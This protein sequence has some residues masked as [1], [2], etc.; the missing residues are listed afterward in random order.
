M[1]LKLNTVSACQGISEQ[2]EL[3][4]SE[5]EDH[6]H[7]RDSKK[8][9]KSRPRGSARGT[10]TVKLTRF[11]GES[12]SGGDEEDSDI[13]PVGRFADNAVI[14]IEKNGYC[15]EPQERSAKLHAPEFFITLK[16]KAL[17]DSIDEHRP[18]EQLHMLPRGLVHARKRR[19]PSRLAR[20]IVQK[21]K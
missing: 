21:M 13:D 4:C 8:Q 2:F 12:D 6:E 9:C 3:G 16:E 14:G 17:R 10:A 19:Y 7:S 5:R 11:I 1:K 20:Q 15:A 18:E